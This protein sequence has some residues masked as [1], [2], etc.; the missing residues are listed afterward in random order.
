MPHGSV[1]GPILFIIFINDLTN[2]FTDKINIKLFADDTKIHLQSKNLSDRNHMQIAINSFLSW[3]NSWQ[4]DIASHKTAIMTLNSIDMPIYYIDNT[5]I[6]T[7]D[8]HKYIGIQFDKYLYFDKHILYCCNGALLTI[9][10]LFRC[11]LTNNITTL[12]KAYITYARPKVQFSTTVWNP[13]LKARRYNGLADKIE[14]VR[15]V[16]TRRLFGRCGLAYISYS[17]R[18]NYLGLQSL[19]L[20]RLHK[21]LIMIYNYIY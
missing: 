5:V 7:C 12:I 13:G 3:S 10:N 1:I 17:E 16:F 6:N 11:F 8:T 9:N 19:A 18:L 20:R 4:L 21:D 2:L 14:R 15:R